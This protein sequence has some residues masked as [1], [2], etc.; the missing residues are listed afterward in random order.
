MQEKRK[1]MFSEELVEQGKIFLGPLMV[2]KKSPRPPSKSIKC[3]IFPIFFDT[4]PYTHCSIQ[5]LR[6]SKSPTKKS[7]IFQKEILLQTLLLHCCGFLLMSLTSA[8][9]RTFVFFVLLI[10]LTNINKTISDGG[11]TVDFWFIKIHTSN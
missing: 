5:K 7:C 3:A 1:I 2:S 8:I 10:I 9:L 6:C 11:I 4:F